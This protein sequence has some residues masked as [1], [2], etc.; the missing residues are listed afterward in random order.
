MLTE[1]TAAQT[2]QLLSL[3]PSVGYVHQS[4]IVI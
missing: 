3:E 1:E 4:A 2:G